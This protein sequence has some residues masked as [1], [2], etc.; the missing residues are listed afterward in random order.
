M[1]TNIEELAREIA[2]AITDAYNNA[3]TDV[4]ADVD[5]AIDAF[6]SVDDAGWR[7]DVYARY[8]HGW[9]TLDVGVECDNA[10]D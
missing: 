10:P 8:H 4:V 6:R 9:F 1:M 3:P 2:R 7:V 5:F